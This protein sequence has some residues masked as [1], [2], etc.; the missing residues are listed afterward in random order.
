MQCIKTGLG[1]LCAHP[2][3]RSHA[4]CAYSAHFVG[5]AAR[6]ASRSR[7][8]RAH[9]QRRSRTCWACTC[10]DMPRQPTPRS[11]PHFDVATSRQPESCC[12]SKSASRP[13]GSQNHVATSN[14][15][16]DIKAAKIMSQHQIDVAT[17]L[18]T[19]QVATSKRGRDTKP[20]VANPPRSRHPFLVATSR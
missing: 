16:H 18:K 20:P 14:C 9:S 11:R 10:R 1:A 13:Q 3:P 7:A 2:E 17:P 6:T 12:D 4:H 15:C 5:A 19:L 8:C